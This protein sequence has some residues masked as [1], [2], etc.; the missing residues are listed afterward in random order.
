MK[1]INLL[2]SSDLEPYIP[3]LFAKEAYRLLF[4]GIEQVD[5]DALIGEF[6]R[7]RYWEAWDNILSKATYTN[8]VGY[9][10][11]LYHDGDL[12]LVCDE[13]L[14]DQEREELYHD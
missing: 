5:I 11:H 1:T 14:T 8:S 2:F 3:R 9:V 12:W 10:Y 4:D 13:L 7:D 6:D